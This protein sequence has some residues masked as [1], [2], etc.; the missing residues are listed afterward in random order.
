MAD[1]PHGASLPA[2]IERQDQITKESAEAYRQARMTA[3]A[4]QAER[5]LTRGTANREMDRLAAERRRRALA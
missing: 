3:E 1:R 5:V 4:E 2:W